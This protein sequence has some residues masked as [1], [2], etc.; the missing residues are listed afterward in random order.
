MIVLLLLELLSCS[1]SRCC[2]LRG[3]TR[4]GTVERGSDIGDIGDMG[5]NGSQH[6]PT[7]H[8]AEMF[9]KIP[10]DSEIA[11]GSR[12]LLETANASRQWLK[13]RGCD[14]AKEDEGADLA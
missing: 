11:R 10:K 9:R 1:I 13:M 7:A 3:P 4:T 8:C 5:R 12:R 14:R 6:A 2:W